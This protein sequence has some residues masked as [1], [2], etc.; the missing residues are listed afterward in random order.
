MNLNHARVCT[1][2]EWARTLQTTV[3]PTVTAGAELG[4]VMLEIGPGPGAATDWLRHRVERLV[5][6]EYEQP[7]AEALAA[8]FAGTNVEVRHGDATA[9][10]FA[11]AAF[12]S[13]ACFTMLHHVPTRALQD[14][15][16]AEV[17]RV[18]RPGGVLV[19][20]DSLAGDGLHHFHEGDTYNPVEPSS[21]LTRLQTLGFENLTIGV[22]GRLTFVAHRPRAAAEDGSVTGAR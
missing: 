17:L 15:L 6:V 14:R 18:L 20:S 7:A 10:P 2:P 9:L 1:S 5:A 21:F 16:L 12:D 8:R 3:L 11:D 13:V 19:G 22:G 4:T